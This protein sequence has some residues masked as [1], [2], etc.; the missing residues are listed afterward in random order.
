MAGIVDV[1][2]MSS[3]AQTLVN[4]FGN[5]ASDRQRQEFR[6]LWS[7]SGPRALSWHGGTRSETLLL[8][9]LG[10]NRIS[11]S[12][13]WPVENGRYWLSQYY[14]PTEAFVDP[15][16]YDGGVPYV[17]IW[18]EEDEWK[19][20]NL[21]K[22]DK[23]LN[24]IAWLPKVAMPTATAI[25]DQINS[26]DSTN[27]G[28]SLNDMPEGTIP[29]DNAQVADKDKEIMDKIGELFQKFLNDP[30]GFI[31]S[32][33]WFPVAAVA[34]FGVVAIKLMRSAVGKAASAALVKRLTPVELKE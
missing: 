2:I 31:T 19:F 32:N 30:I 22:I 24:Q 16:Q 20:E 33:P 18:I 14:L 8:S 5:T 15:S 28:E 17:L 7:Q 9:K 13:S 34:V 6:V 12:R 29:K 4:A 1:A 23:N 27:V 3:L 25:S 21:Y 10:W 11:P 26:G